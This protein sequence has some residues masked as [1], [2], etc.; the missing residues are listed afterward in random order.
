MNP[1][2][3]FGI[4]FNFGDELRLDGQAIVEPV[5]LDGAN[6]IS[7]R[8]SLAGSVDLLG[9]RFYE[10][11]GYPFLGLPLAELR[12]QTA[13]LDVLDRPSLLRLHT[14]LQEAGSLPARLSLL[15]E[16]LTGRLSLG[17][18]RSAMVPASLDLLRAARLSIPE[19]ARELAIGQRQLER[20]YQSQ[21]GMSPKQYSLLLR[22]E[23]ARQALKRI[24]LQPSFTIADLAAELGFFDQS[25]FIHEFSAVTGT[26]PYAYLKRTRQEPETA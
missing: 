18:E 1:Q 26:T 16:W 21:V 17:K 11:G 13:L 25:H 7:R 5:F 23:S 14:R 15:E 2:G 12:N 20:L 24:R 4:I 22:V 19:L 8:V 6:T 10:G 9:I 3:G